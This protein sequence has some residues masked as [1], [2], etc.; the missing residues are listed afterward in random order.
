MIKKRDKPDFYQY[1][2]ILVPG[3]NLTVWR[4][5]SANQAAAMPS[6]IGMGCVKGKDTRHE[7]LT[8]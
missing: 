2:N 5:Y 7:M 3:C 1:F 8:Y 6:G 4:L